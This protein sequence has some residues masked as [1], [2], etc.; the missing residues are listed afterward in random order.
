MKREPNTIFDPPVPIIKTRAIIMPSRLS[1]VVTQVVTQK[2]RYKNA[3]NIDKLNSLTFKSQFAKTDEETGDE[4]VTSNEEDQSDAEGENVTRKKDSDNTE[5]D[6]GSND[7]KIDQNNTHENDS[8][9]GV[10]FQSL[11]RSVH[12]S[13]VIKPNKRFTDDSKTI[14]NKNGFGRKKG[15]KVNSETDAHESNKKGIQTKS[16][17][18]L[19]YYFHEILIK[20]FFI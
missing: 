18:Q 5:S 15:L 11:K 12:S 19:N 3:N 17:L 13:R 16:T 2:F 8:T 7:G 20:I 9:K 10:S 1:Q 14:N 6:E 4:T